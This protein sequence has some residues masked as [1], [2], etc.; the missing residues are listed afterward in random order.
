MEEATISETEPN[1]LSA[2]FHHPAF[3]TGL[4]TVFQG[5]VSYYEAAGLLGPLAL[6]VALA[7]KDSREPQYVLY[8]LTLI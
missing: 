5:T 1:A 4:A 7:H 2:L 8:L 3:H 6:K